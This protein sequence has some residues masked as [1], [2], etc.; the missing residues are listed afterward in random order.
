MARRFDEAGS[1]LRGVLEVAPDAALPRQFLARVLL[2]TDQAAEVLKLL[3]GRNDPGPGSHS[4]LGRAYAKLG[5][6]AGARAEIERAEA[7]VPLGYGVGWDLS[8]LY[9]E[10]G[11][12]ERAVEWLERAVDDR[13]QMLGYMNF[14]PALDPLRDDPRLAAIAARIN[15]A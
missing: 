1:T 2:V 8:L 7:R 10:L 3:E 6:L 9:L 11:D 15:L 4:N 13:S 5:N 12:L 14:E